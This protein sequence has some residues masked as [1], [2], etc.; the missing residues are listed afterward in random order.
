MGGGEVA[1]V[2]VEG[3]AGGV[4]EGF[5][6]LVKVEGGWGVEGEGE[7]WMA[8]SSS[9]RDLSWS[10]SAFTASYLSLSTLHLS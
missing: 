10:L 4:A 8:S 1:I 2:G 3:G 5:G 7:D 6:T 9:T